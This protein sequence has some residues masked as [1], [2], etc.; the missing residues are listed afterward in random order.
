MR[1]KRIKS[2]EDAYYHLISRIVDKDFKYDEEERQIFYFIMRKVARFC[3]VEVVTFAI[4]SNHFHILAFVP[5]PGSVE[6]TEQMLLE[7]VGILYGSEEAEDMGKRW[8]EWRELG[9]LHLVT[10]EQEKLRRRMGDVSMFM[11]ELKQRATICYN[12]RHQREGT[13]WEGRFKSVLVE[14][15]SDALEA[16]AAY[17]DL[18]P[19][20][21]GM[22][23]DPADYR[24]SGYGSA[25]AGNRESR[26]G[27]ELVYEGGIVG[28]NPWRFVSRDYR[29]ILYCKGVAKDRRKGFTEEEIQATLDKGGKLPLPTLLRCKMRQFSAG[30]VFGSKK[31]IEK[32]FKDYAEA[33]CEKQCKMARP[34]PSCEGRDALC[35]AQRGRRRKAEA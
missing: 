8:K 21:A 16:I 1:K 18:N 2:Q 14:P 28:E 33:F 27:L 35:V 3:G 34:L 13:M 23:E 5:A 4:M 32:A 29:Q 19:V 6:V 24:W 31:F 25:C 15:D 20:R 7:R 12:A 11:K 17:I 26:R 10:E 9:M 22:V 30:M